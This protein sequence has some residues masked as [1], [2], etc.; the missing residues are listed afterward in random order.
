MYNIIIKI[1]SNLYFFFMSF[2]HTYW[3]F[4]ALPGITMSIARFRLLPVTNILYDNTT[5]SM[6][7]INVRRRNRIYNNIIY[8]LYNHNQLYEY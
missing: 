6:V 4:I 1:N 5:A 8:S 7:E 2:A 3:P